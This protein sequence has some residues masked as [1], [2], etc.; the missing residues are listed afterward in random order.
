MG[1]NF[2]RY[3]WQYG[4]I[5]ICFAVVASKI[6]E[7]LRNS[8]KIRTKGQTP[9]QH[10]SLTENTKNEEYTST[11]LIWINQTWYKLQSVKSAVN[12]KNKNYATAVSHFEF[13]SLPSFARYFRIRFSQITLSQFRVSQITHSHRVAASAKNREFLLTLPAGCDSASWWVSLKIAS[14]RLN[15]SGVLHWRY[16]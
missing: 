13:R 15:V 3:R 1:F 6:C 5:F 9:L 11:A 14:W 12:S 7:I 2:Q 10:N 4:S 8:P 16:S